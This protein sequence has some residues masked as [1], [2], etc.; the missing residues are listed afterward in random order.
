[1]DDDS[2]NQQLQI[3]FFIFIFIYKKS[4]EKTRT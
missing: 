3:Y 1:M 2:I 4:Y